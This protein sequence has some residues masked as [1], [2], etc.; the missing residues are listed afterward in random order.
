MRSRIFESAIFFCTLG[1]VRAYIVDP[2]TTALPDTVQD[3]SAWVVAGPGES[4]NNLA[5]EFLISIY[6]FAAYV[7]YSVFAR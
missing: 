6:Q 4:C 3:C 2:P 5:N 1:S 7:C